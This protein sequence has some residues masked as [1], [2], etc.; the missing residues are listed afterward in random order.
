[1]NEQ[2][3][4]HAQIFVAFD[5]CGEYWSYS[6]TKSQNTCYIYF[7]ECVGIAVCTGSW[8]ICSNNWSWI[9]QNCNKR[10]SALNALSRLNILPILLKLTILEHAIDFNHYL[11][12][13]CSQK[14]KRGNFKFDP[15]TTNTPQWICS[16]VLQTRQT[17][18]FLA[19][20][21]I[22]KCNW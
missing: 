19:S 11:N 16:L 22:Y 18:R 14:Q 15:W 20:R 13:H 10:V 3:W 8:Q 21:Q 6:H 2:E 12:P 7:P 4:V 1:M 17:T 9:S 5:I